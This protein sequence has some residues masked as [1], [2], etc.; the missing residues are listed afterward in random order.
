MALFFWRMKKEK[1]FFQAVG[2][3]LA[4]VLL[5]P[6]LLLFRPVEQPK[7]TTG[8]KQF[9]A[10]EVS[11]GATVSRDDILLMARV[12]EGEAADE[13]YTGKV[14]VGAVIVNR[15]NSPGFPKTIPGVVYEP[16][17]F[18][19]VTNGQYLRPLMPEAIRAAQEALSGNDPTGGALYYW[20]PA[21]ATSTWVWSR[22][23]VTRIGNHVFAR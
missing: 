21:R 23:V 14:A 12:I 20:N 22:P 9:P 11:R 17:A 3:F 15:L 1:A 13:P 18:E 4:T 6:T 2:I 7:S 16:D 19:A 8:H 10:G 5:F